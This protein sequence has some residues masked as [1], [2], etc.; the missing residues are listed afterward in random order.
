MLA[1][2]FGANEIAVTFLPWPYKFTF[3]LQIDAKLITQESVTVVLLFG[4]F[5]ISDE[6]KGSETLCLVTMW[7]IH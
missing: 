5:F 6:W 1:R 2:M 7:N 3:D 4:T